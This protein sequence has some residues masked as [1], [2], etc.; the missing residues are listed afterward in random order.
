M[1]LTMPLLSA[2]GFMRSAENLRELVAA[3]PTSV[4]AVVTTVATVGL[5]PTPQTTECGFRLAVSFFGALC[6]AKAG[7]PESISSDNPRARPQPALKT[8]LLS[9][10][11]SWLLVL[12]DLRLL[13]INF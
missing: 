5:P 7:T 6:P 9:K 11:P 4:V 8:G 13:F 10:R 3:V 1:T 2:V 12:S